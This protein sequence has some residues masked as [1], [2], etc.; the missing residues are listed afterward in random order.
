MAGRKWDFNEYEIRG[1]YAVILLARRNGEVYE[2][3]V[4]IADLEKLKA[5]GWHWSA[6]W[7]ENSHDYYATHTEYIGNCKTRT[8]LMHKYLLGAMEGLVDHINHDCLDNR[9]GNLRITD[10]VGNGRNRRT[11]PSG[12]THTAIYL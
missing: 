10:H 8:R 9:R 3:K 4:D 12:R 5:L 7:N 11:A 2:C 6:A 1:D